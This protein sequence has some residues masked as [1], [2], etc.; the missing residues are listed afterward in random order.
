MSY[1]ISSSISI[2]GLAAEENTNEDDFSLDFIFDS[3][4]KK[5][6]HYWFEMY[7]KTNISVKWALDLLISK[8]YLN[9]EIFLIHFNLFKFLIYKM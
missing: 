6:T 7:R 5:I 3:L 8:I 4:G 2:C 1:F 9:L